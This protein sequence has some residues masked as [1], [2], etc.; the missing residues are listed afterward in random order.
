MAS[1]RTLAFFACLGFAAMTP[2]VTAQVGT[3][4]SSENAFL[5]INQDLT[6][7]AD[8]VLANALVNQSWMSAEGRSSKGERAG[9]AVQRGS[10]LKVRAALDRVNR[11][12]PLLEPILR[13][14][15]VPVEL[16]AVVLVESG[17]LPAALSPKGARGVWQFMPD[18]ARRYGLIVDRSRDERLDVGKSTHAAAQYLRELHLQFG[19]WSLALAA[20]NAGELTVR[21]AIERNRS[22]DVGSIL[23]S[24]YLPAETRS[25]VH[26]IN[27]SMHR[28][29]HEGL[30]SAPG[31]SANIVYASPVS[32]ER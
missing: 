30:S 3:P 11:L 2:V 6:E 27:A 22:S 1:Q 7:A 28:L 25:Y 29:H 31:E 5:S 4:A 19:D 10:T 14:E 17:G 24:E 26:A 23:A 8:R 16:S 15:G 18:T 20:Y 9:S 13:D 32:D 21:K 12:R